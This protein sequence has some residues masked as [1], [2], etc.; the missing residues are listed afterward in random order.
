MKL[1]LFATILVCVVHNICASQDSNWEL[2]LPT[3]THPVNMSAHSMVAVPNGFLLFG[4][5]QEYFNARTIT[6]FNDVYEVNLVDGE[7]TKKNT[8]GTRPSARAYCSAVYS[9]SN[10]LMY[11]FGG[12]T[13]NAFYGNF[14]PLNDLWTYSADNDTWTQIQFDVSAALPTTRA[15]PL[16]VI[17]SQHIY[18][19]G[20]VTRS[21]FAYAVLNDLW[22]FDIEANTWTLLKA[23]GDVNSP[24]P[25]Q[26]PVGG[27]LPMKNSIIM[28][29]GEFLQGFSFFEAKDTWIYS[30]NSDTWEDV[31]PEPDNNLLPPRNF[32]A[33]GVF[34][35]N[36]VI[37][38]GD[39]PGGSAGCGAPF[40][41]FFQN[42]MNETWV[43][44]ARPNSRVWYKLN[45]AVGPEP[46]KRHAFAVLSNKLCIHGGY[47]FICDSN[48]AG[49]GQVFPD[50]RE[51]YCLKISNV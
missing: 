4:G 17:K 29:G 45:T 22:R 21:G 33:G 27:Y 48:G 19:F 37:Y 42:A 1:F 15:G 14:N 26:V 44:D 7:W 5:H 20:G 41:S 49:P 46:K 12:A 13:F 38:G 24:P 50:G 30:I 16:M 6:F 8:P 9:P 28:N 40:G 2:L 34:A 10:R 43:F 23:N 25:R 32:A 51:I 39:A 3:G 18:L 31:T 11:V 35:N 47:D 36:F